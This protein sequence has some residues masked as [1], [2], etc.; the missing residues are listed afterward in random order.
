MLDT[1]SNPVLSMFT[2]VKSEDDEMETSGAKME[3]E[4]HIVTVEAG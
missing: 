2:G 4:E 1:C 3:Q